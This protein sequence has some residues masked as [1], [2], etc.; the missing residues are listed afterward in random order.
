MLFQCTSSGNIT[1]LFLKQK[2]RRHFTTEKK[3][4][5]SALHCTEYVNKNQKKA[6][7]LNEPSIHILLFSDYSWI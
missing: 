3:R 4:Q 2:G 5:E 1:D 6:V 7:V